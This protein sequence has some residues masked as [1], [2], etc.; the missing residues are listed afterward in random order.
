VLFFDAGALTNALNRMKKDD[1]KTSIGAALRIVTP[2]GFVSIEY[3]IPFQPGPGTDPT[4]RVHFNFGFI[5]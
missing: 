4:G 1:W 2:V 3:A 5:F